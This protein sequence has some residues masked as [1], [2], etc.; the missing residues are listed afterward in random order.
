MTATVAPYLVMDL[1][2][3]FTGNPGMSTD[4][5]FEAFADRVLAALADLESAD[6]G[7]SDPD[8]TASLTRREISISM[9]VEADTI[10]DAR[11]IFAANVRT[12]LHV[13]GS[14][15]ADWPFEL[16]DRALPTAQQVDPAGA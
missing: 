13:A 15:T 16:E 9:R 4:E 3:T 10:D 11:R 6:P 14:R 8:I 1:R 12:A 2:V 7:L 5:K